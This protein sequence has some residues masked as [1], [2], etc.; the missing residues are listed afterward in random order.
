MSWMKM[1]D[2]L[3][4]GRNLTIHFFPPYVTGGIS[5]R[6]YGSINFEDG[7]FVETS[8]IS[9]GNLENGSVVVTSSGSRYFL[10][11][12]PAVKQANIMAAIKDMSAA[13]P[14]S[15]ITLT[16]EKKVR[17]AKAA[18]DAVQNAKPRATFSLFGLGLGDENEAPKS[19]ASPRA[20]SA[21]KTP[22]K[23]PIKK[24]PAKAPA[25]T[26]PKAPATAPRG[27]PTF[28]RWKRNGDGSVTGIISGSKSF[29]DGEKV[30]TS[31][32][33]KGKIAKGEIVT[34]GSGSRYFLS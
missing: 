24:T 23:A 17:E 28:S 7:D 3:C 27:V 34:T 31:M 16:K 15:T 20:A 10:S 30:T 2:L 1:S 29:N 32:I 33:A 6:I 12:E 4:V 25:K 5:G 9:S 14:G 21:V 22:V 13:K 8:P 18:V 26:P 11:S 19:K